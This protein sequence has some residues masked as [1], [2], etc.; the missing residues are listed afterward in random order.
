MALPLPREENVRNV[1]VFLL[2]LFFGFFKS[3]FCPPGL[4]VKGQGVDAG[5]LGGGHVR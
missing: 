4:A 1:R 3:R 5:A 2:P